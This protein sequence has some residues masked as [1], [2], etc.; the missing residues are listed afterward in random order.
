MHWAVR[1]EKVRTVRAMGRM[2][3]QGL[4]PVQR[5]AITVTACYPSKR[6]TQDVP[7]IAGTV[8]KAAIDGIVTD[9]GLLPDDDSE[10][11]VSVTYRRGP[12]TGKKDWF[13]LVVTL[14]EVE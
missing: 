3:S 7:N 4:E 13:R 12:D 14:D 11:V 10:H 9:S 2:R 6:Y 1:A 5:A 8:A